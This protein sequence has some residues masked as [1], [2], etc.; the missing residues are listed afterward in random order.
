M[1]IIMDTPL[2][3]PVTEAS[4]A[5]PLKKDDKSAREKLAGSGLLLQGQSETTIENA[6]V[7]AS[8]VVM[9]TLLHN[10]GPV[11]VQYYTLLPEYGFIFHLSAPAA[12]DTPFNY[13][14]L[15]GELF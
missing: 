6:H 13:V 15:L 9:V 8:S 12:S 11:V 14:I 3:Q 2:D 1:P 7:S 4:V 5:V 10:P